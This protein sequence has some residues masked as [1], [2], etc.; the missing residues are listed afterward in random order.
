[1]IYHSFIVEFKQETFF[2]NFFPFRLSFVLEIKSIIL[3]NNLF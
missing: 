2:A 3:T 1:M